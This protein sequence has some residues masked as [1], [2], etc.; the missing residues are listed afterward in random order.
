M[1]ENPR[2]CYSGYAVVVPASSSKMRVNNGSKSN[3]YENVS[4]TGY[5]EEY[6]GVGYSSH[7]TESHKGGDFVNKRTG[8]M[9]YKKEIKYTSTHKFN[10]KV[11]GYSGEYETQVKVRK[12]INY[13]TNNYSKSGSS[14]KRVNFY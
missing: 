10:D 11:E 1:G 8:Q 4:R 7:F 6:N 12:T 3:E 13:H 9:G 2:K 14:S 5:K